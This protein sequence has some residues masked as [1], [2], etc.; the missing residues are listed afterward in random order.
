MLSSIR[1]FSYG[2]DGNPVMH[3]Q[4][5]RL[6]QQ[7]AS[8]LFHPA[9]SDKST[10]E[11]IS[12]SRLWQE[13]CSDPVYKIKEEAFE[14]WRPSNT[15]LLK[16]KL[17]VMM[18]CEFHFTKCSTFFWGGRRPKESKRWFDLADVTTNPLSRHGQ[19]LEVNGVS[20]RMSRASML[21]TTPVTA[22]SSWRSMAL[23]RQSPTPMGLI[24]RESLSFKPYVRCTLF[25]F[26]YLSLDFFILF[27]PLVFNFFLFVF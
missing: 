26:F 22:C 27:F 23:S 8:S 2:G 10:V 24:E 3:D 11:E 16:K 19:R 18:T 5:S 13:L 15:W 6:Q 12:R 4:A 9:A 20:F 17:A 21:P 25:A 1:S 14:A 7:P